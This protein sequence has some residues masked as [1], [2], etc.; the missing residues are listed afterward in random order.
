M[1]QTDYNSYIKQYK[2][3]SYGCR[4]TSALVSCQMHKWIQRSIF[5]FLYIYICVFSFSAYPET[6]SVCS[7][8]T[9][10]HL[11]R[12]VW[13][14]VLVHILAIQLMTWP[15]LWHRYCSKKTYI[16]TL[17]RCGQNTRG[18]PL[19]SYCLRRESNFLA[20]TRR[21]TAFCMRVCCIVCVCYC[22]MV[23][24]KPTRK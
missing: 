8:V 1:K 6:D 4:N 23:I 5:G 7:S 16:W 19:Y 15:E 3:V 2:F 14:A 12:R 22:V 20:S 17:T 13:K 10:L 21:V 18:F 24:R 11:P 9:L